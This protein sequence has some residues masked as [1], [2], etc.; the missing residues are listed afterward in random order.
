MRFSSELT[1]PRTGS[2]AISR[3]SPLKSCSPQGTRQNVAFLC[4]GTFSAVASAI[5]IVTWSSLENTGIV[6]KRSSRH[7]EGSA[8][9]GQYRK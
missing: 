9:E 1:Y 8:D 3:Y 5:D 7:N 6:V 4:P 2:G